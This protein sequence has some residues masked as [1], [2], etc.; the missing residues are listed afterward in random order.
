MANKLLDT[1]TLS[2]SIPH[3][4][5]WSLGKRKGLR[6][7]REAS[8]IIV[9][10]T[11]LTVYWS[12]K[13][14]PQEWGWMESPQEKGNVL[15]TWVPWGNQWSIFFQWMINRNLT[16]QFQG[17]KLLW[18]RSP[19]KLKVHD[20]QKF[21]PIKDAMFST[22]KGISFWPIQPFLGGK[23]KKPRLNFWQRLYWFKKF[24][25]M[26]NLNKEK[27]LCSLG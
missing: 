23:S 26:I 19:K 9:H 15:I 16:N 20:L 12:A 1:L 7:P 6:C 13:K 17:L 4:T 18:I 2:P 25:L 14:P 3:T 8:L 24:L 5:C 21:L 22:S 27:H 11:C 10:F